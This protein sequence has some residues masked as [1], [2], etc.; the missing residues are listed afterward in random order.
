M[1]PGRASK[2]VAPNGHNEAL[3]HFDRRFSQRYRERPD[4]GREAAVA[5]H[6]LCAKHGAPKV[7][8]RIDTAFDA[9]PHWMTGVITWK[10]FVGQFDAFVQSGNGSRRSSAGDLL[11]RADQM[12]R[13]G[14]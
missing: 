14:S 6:R 3:A 2:A 4:L 13:G 10:T 12:R 9:P 7:M 5:F 1:K 11:R 8:E